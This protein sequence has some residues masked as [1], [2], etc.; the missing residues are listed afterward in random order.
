ML[1]LVT[2]AVV[3]VLETPPPSS[4]GPSTTLCLCS[5]WH[6][7][8]NPPSGAVAGN[9]RGAS[10]G[11]TTN[12]CTASAPASVRLPCSHPTSTA[13]DFPPSTPPT[14]KQLGTMAAIN[15]IMLVQKDVPAAHLL[16]LGPS[17]R[18]RL[19]TRVTP[20]RIRPC[21]GTAPPPCAARRHA[22]SP[23]ADA[24]RRLLDHASSCR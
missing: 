24:A 19:V 9:V 8:R 23:L 11:H 6:R 5:A 12:R 13:A 16:L 15:I 18:Q 10:R 21:Q 22:A 3:V 4:M 7:P 1:G 17:Y 20:S 2:R 14:T